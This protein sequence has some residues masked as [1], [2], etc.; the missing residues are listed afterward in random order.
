MARSRRNRGMVRGDPKKVSA[1]VKEVL[2]SRA[3]EKRNIFT[4]GST[5]ATTAGVVIPITQGIVQGDEVFQ[6]NGDQIFVRR[7]DWRVKNTLATLGVVAV[8]RF[9][10][11]HDN[12]NVGVLPAVTDVLQAATVTADYH[13]VNGI[14]RR[15]I[16]LLDRTVDLCANGIATHTFHFT[17]KP[18][19]KIQYAT[20]TDVTVAN[21]KGAL[22]ALVVCD[23][24]LNPPNYFF[25]V[26]V[27]Y[28]DF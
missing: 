4:Q 24:A 1:V 6:R 11:F 10:L 13:V 22:F 7:I 23:A 3:E 18:K 2:N 9:L 25:D 17:S 12:H 27:Q 20:G 5:S 16:I 14:Q 21:R 8:T 28:T 26:A 19:R 15:F